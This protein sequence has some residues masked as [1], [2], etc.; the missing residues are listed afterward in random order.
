MVITVHQPPI[1]DAHA[2]HH[3]ACSN[4][5]DTL[6]AKGAVKY[7]WEPGKY[8]TDTVILNPPLSAT[9]TVTGTD[10]FGCVN[11]DTASIDVVF[12]PSN[13]THF[14]TSVYK[15]TSIKLFSSNKHST[16]YLWKPDTALSDTSARY[17]ICT[18]EKPETYLVTYLDKNG[19]Y[20]LDTFFVKL[21]RDC[22]GI[23]VP[24]AFSPN[25]D[26]VNDVLKLIPSHGETLLLFRVYNRWGH[27]VFETNDVKVSWDGSFNGQSLDM[28]AYVYYI[29]FMCTNG[30]T[31]LQKGNITLIK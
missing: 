26:G 17:P 20:V 18:P 12:K 3:L 29:Q 7:L 9:F 1:L 15:G 22:L 13:G 24:N 11:S 19:C 10:S 27:L 30:Q 23:F 16:Y 28:D 8:R 6:V 21:K 4:V 31:I 25:G 5:P 14:D 2:T